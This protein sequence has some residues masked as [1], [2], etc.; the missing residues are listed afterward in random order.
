M[1]T[2]RQMPCIYGGLCNQGKTSSFSCAKCSI[3]SPRVRERHLNKM[4]KEFEKIQKK[5]RY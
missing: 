4:K 2:D 3:Y 5:E 1:A